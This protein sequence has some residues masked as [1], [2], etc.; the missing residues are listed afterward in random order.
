MRLPC[1]AG[2]SLLLLS[3]CAAKYE[4][5]TPELQTSMLGDLKSGK[6]T[7]DCGLT[8]DI[9]FIT[10]ASSLHAL[11]MAE[12]WNDLATHVMQIGYGN[13]L[14]YYYLGQAA[15]GLGYHQAAI[16]YYSY[17]LALSSGQDALLQCAAGRSQTVDP[18]QGVDLAGSIPVL[19]Q[20]SR[21]AIAQQAQ[22][23]E[24]AAEAATQSPAPVHH[25]RTEAST[26]SA[27]WVTPQPLSNQ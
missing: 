22:A 25:H 27:T 21:D 15:Q 14:A 10:Q 24:A 2:L 19:I 8:C 13:D 12:R 1:L 9:T 23:D 26:A 7:L 20:A 6:L 3:G 17:A 18:C 5:L 11:D 4:A 16:G